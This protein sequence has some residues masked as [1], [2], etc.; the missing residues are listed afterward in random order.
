MLNYFSL[1]D[2]SLVYL[3]IP[4]NLRR[5]NKIEIYLKYPKKHFILYSSIINKTTQG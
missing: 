3:F 5:S 4:I 2:L 1:A